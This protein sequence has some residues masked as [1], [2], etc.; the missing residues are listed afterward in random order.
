MSKIVK[1]KV[2]RRLSKK[3][4]KIIIEFFIILAFFIYILFSVLGGKEESDNN[5]NPLIDLKPEKKVTVE[6]D[7][8]KALMLVKGEHYKLNSS[9]EDVTWSSSNTEVA[10]VSSSGEITAFGNGTAIISAT[11]LSSSDSVEVMV[12]DLVSKPYVNNKKEALPCNKYSLDEVN[13]MDKYLEYIIN[14]VGYNTRAG[15]V[16]AARFLTLQFKYKINYFY[17]NGRLYT[18]GGRT[19]ADGEGRWYRKGLYLH[20]EKKKQVTIS[21]RGPA[22]WGCPMYEGITGKTTANG[23]D[24]SGFVTWA[25]VNAGFDPK[26]IGAG[27]SS[28][29]DLSD[30][31]EKLTINKDNIN[32]S[33]IKIGDLFSRNGHIGML[34]GI[35]NGTYYIAESLDTDLHIQ[36]TTKEKILKSD[37][38]Y[39]ILMD[40]FYKEDGKLTQIW[41]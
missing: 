34:A 7:R 26:D 10:T 28:N 37:W 27:I 12:T 9:Y 25:L 15:A 8:E 6:L 1:K 16:E 14:E 21:N 33:N 17:E 4:K 2:R 23:L 41:S 13:T 38:K 40:N 30:L 29:Y 39:I 11:Y 32:S 35:D 22:I 18:A 24:C 19:L 36:V 3:G 20:D 31:G 5:N